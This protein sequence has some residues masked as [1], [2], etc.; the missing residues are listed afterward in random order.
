MNDGM[1]D[2]ASSLDDAALLRYSRQIM[3]PEIDIAG[4]EKLAAARVLVVGLGGLGSPLSIYL[5]CAGVG[6]LALADFDQVELA[7]L[8]RQILHD[9]CFLGMRK[10]E[11]ARERLRALNANTRII[12]VDGNMTEQGERLR[13][14][15]QKADVVADAS[16]NFRTRFALN[17]VCMENATPLVSGAAIR[18][19][20]QIS[21]F[22]PRQPDGPC[23]RCLYDEDS[24]VD[25]SCTANGVLAPLLGIIGSMQA[26][27]VLKLLM[28]IGAPLRGRLLLLDILHAQVQEA[29]LEKDPQCPVCSSGSRPEVVPG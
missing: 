3:L 27:E 26:C 20:G 28:G 18:F 6:T 12:L 23:Y 8:Q 9:E 11:S 7:N 4:Q 2:T 21:V 25:A 16:D 13:E 14:Q 10:T 1:N 29:R 17:A 24:S 5:G 15:V 19:E 22:D